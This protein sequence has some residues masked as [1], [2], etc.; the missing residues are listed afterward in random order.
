MT[1][2]NLVYFADQEELI[3]SSDLSCHLQNLKPLIINIS[4][5]SFWIKYSNS[6]SFLTPSIC[7]D[8]LDS[9]KKH[10]RYHYYYCALS[11]LHH[12]F[13]KY[14]DQTYFKN[15][16]GRSYNPS[17]EQKT[18]FSLH[19]SS[20][21]LCYLDDNYLLEETIFFT[22]SINDLIK[23]LLY[24]YFQSKVTH[25]YCFSDVSYKSYYFIEDFASRIPN[26]SSKYLLWDLNKSTSYSLEFH[27]DDTRSLSCNHNIPSINRSARVSVDFTEHRKFSLDIVTKTKNT[28]DLSTISNAF[29]QLWNLPLQL[30]FNA[31]SLRS[32]CLPISIPLRNMY[33]SRSRAYFSFIQF[34]F[35]EFKY[36]LKRFTN[37]L[38]VYFLDVSSVHHIVSNSSHIVFLHYFPEG[39]I[40]S[41]NSY[42]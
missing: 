36:A 25:L 1:L 18:L 14:F 10:P 37:L 15:L 34:L 3:A 28:S 17:F 2:K 35:V 8:L 16:S 23:Q 12:S 13:N 33:G 22:P 24:F 20:C 30:I 7:L 11:S 27:V 29:Y 9:F 32:L 41:A 42:A 5:L 26:V 31:S 40:L 4:P 39:P 19:Y 21:I 6:S 38:S